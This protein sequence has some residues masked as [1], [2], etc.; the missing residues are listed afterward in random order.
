MRAISRR[1]AGSED[2]IGGARS[3][4]GPG[5]RTLTE[6][7]QCKAD[8]PAAP[9]EAFAVATSGQG[10]ALPHQS[11]MESAFGRSFGGVSA[12]VGTAQA[13]AGLAGLGARAA[14]FGDTVAFADANPD[15]HLVAHEVAHVVQ[16]RNGGGGGVQAKSATAVSQPGDA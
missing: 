7:L 12:H 15:P 6:Q 2:P 13:Q 3:G 9:G 14:A 16:A 11:R 4:P 5:K 8:A 10:G 1:Q